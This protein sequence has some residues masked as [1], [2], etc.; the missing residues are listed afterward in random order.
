VQKEKKNPT[1]GYTT[2]TFSYSKYVSNAIDLNT[3]A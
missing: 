2:L 1:Q 3:K